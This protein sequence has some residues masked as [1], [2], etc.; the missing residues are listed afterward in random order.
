MAGG[1]A[2]RSTRMHQDPPRTCNESALL[3]FQAN[4]SDLEVVS[5]A[6]LSLAVCLRARIRFGQEVKAVTDSANDCIIVG[7]IRLRSEAVIAEPSFADDYAH[8]PFLSSVPAHERGGLLF[9]GA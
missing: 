4:G 7:P 6:T 2:R 9:R 3:H 1:S 8:A 5:A